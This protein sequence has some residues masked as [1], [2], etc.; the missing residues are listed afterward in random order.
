MAEVVEL[1]SEEK[2]ESGFLCGCCSNEIK[3]TDEVFLVRIV[4][5]FILDGKLE[6]LDIIND[7]GEY[8]YPPVFFD[9]DCWEEEESEVQDIQSD[10]Q[11]IVAHEGIIL[12]D[13]CESDICQGEA[14]GLV[15]FGE[16]R[17]TDRQPNNQLSAS[18]VG[19]AEHQHLCIACITHL[20]DSQR[21]PV[22]AGEIEPVPG[23]EV[24]VEGVFERCWRNN[25]CACP[26]RICAS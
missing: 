18:F 5:P 17:L 11:P 3:L 14:M 8:K 26:N 1:E 13:I 22:W 21:E 25:G 7:R 20:E 19:L 6:Y 2:I 12:C 9:F 16:I 15:Q 4:H 23:V 10:V 24:C